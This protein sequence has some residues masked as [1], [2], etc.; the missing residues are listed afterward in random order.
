MISHWQIVAHATEVAKPG[1]YVRMPGPYGREIVVSNF[2][3][4]VKVWDN[5]CPHRGAR[6]YQD[7]GGNRQPVCSY[8]GRCAKS[9]AVGAY[10]TLLAGEWVYA[11]LDG[12]N[13]GR[14]P[15]NTPP[16]D[17]RLYARADFVYDCEFQVAIENALDF[18]HVAFAHPNSL[19][20]LD[21]SPG[22]IQLEKLGSSAQAFKSGIS[23]RLDLLEP[24]FT[25]GQPSR[26]RWGEGVDYW[27]SYASPFMC[28]SSTRGFT[29]SLQLYIPRED[30]KTTLV[31]RMYA[32]LHTPRAEGFL[33]SAF[34][35]NC[36]VFEEDA[37]LCALV[38]ADHASQ[39]EH[40]EQ[41]IA[42]FRE[43]FSGA[44]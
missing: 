31:H 24:L 41:R 29:Y 32:A 34:E 8:H 22:E 39:A 7:D 37:K 12:Q 38:P 13:G 44:M 26:P 3:G 11:I 36:R 19:A 30:G 15:G 17:M 10:P 2:D 35:T 25:G 5:R 1:D 6:I 27:H 14:M 9:D 4:L 18:E 40:H 16:N 33:R 28:V 43:Y 21:L 23:R 20:R 42:H